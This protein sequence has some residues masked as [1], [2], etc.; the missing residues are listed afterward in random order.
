MSET[1][2]GRPASEV[3]EA[4]APAVFIHAVAAPTAAAVAAVPAPASAA[5][6]GNRD[7]ERLRRYERLLWVALLAHKPRGMPFQGTVLMAFTL[8][9]SGAVLEAHVARSAGMA[10]L[11]RAALAALAA[12]APFPPPPPGLTAAQLR[13]SIPFTFQ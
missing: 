8:S 5:S 2:I 13:F 10:A 4:P 12:A 3:L 9:A 11:D 1:I 7:D 6:R